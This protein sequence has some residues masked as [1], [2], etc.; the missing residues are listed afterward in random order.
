MGTG[1]LLPRIFK[2]KG[3]TLYLYPQNEMTERT[4]SKYM[5]AEAI[6][7]GMTHQVGQAGPT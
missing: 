3:N 5:N 6:P 2:C 7:V 1:L 4:I